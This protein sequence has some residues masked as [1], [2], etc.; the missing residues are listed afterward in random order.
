MFPSDFAEILVAHCDGGI[1]LAR[2]VESMD[3]GSEIKQLAQR[4][5]AGEEQDRSTVQSWMQTQIVA[6]SQ[7]AQIE[8]ADARKEHQ[9]A[10]ER[11][12]QTVPSEKE[13]HALR[14]MLSHH[15]EELALLEETPVE[16]K[17]L[18]AVVK[19]IWQR[20]SIQV[21]DLEQRLPKAP[22]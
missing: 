2:A 17:A 7:M 15:R 11:L 3:V 5:R 16:D 14:V 6:P 22:K 13:D 1:E 19:S 8:S 12:L 10:V 9:A 4:V 20:L 18:R 21:K